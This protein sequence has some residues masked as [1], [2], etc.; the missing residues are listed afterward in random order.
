[1]EAGGGNGNG[2]A[3]RQ[4]VIALETEMLRARNRLHEQGNRIVEH[5]S[6]LESMG[7]TLRR[8]DTAVSALHTELHE[9]FDRQASR[10][11]YVAGFIVSAVGVAALIV[12]VV[13]SS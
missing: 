5:E 4:R 7:R 8:L 3:L 9:G 11:W 2:N 10:S 6:D 1:M 13:L 12:S